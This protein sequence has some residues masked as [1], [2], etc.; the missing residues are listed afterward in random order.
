[1]DEDGRLLNASRSFGERR[2]AR[3]ILESSH[4]IETIMHFFGN[5]NQ[6]ARTKQAAP[7]HY[8]KNTRKVY[9]KE[10]STCR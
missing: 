8:Y 7:S 2:F 3:E 10:R 5:F 6:Q 4:C 9:L 1:M